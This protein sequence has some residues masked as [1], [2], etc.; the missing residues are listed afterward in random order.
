MAVLVLAAALIAAPAAQA[1]ITVGS[2]LSAPFDNSIGGNITAF[3]TAPASLVT[4][5]PVTGTVVGGNVKQGGSPVNAWGSASLR[6]VH[7]L[8]GGLY[9]VTASG[10]ANAIPAG[11]GIFPLSAHVAI[12][13]GDLVAIQGTGQ[14]DEA[15]SAGATYLF[16][17]TSTFPTG[18][19]PAMMSGGNTNTELLYNAQIDPTNT[20]TL[21]APTILKKGKAT[22]VVTVP[23]P[24]AIGGGS[25]ND[26]GLA[27]TAKKKKKKAK[28]LLAQVSATAAD[29]GPVTL[30]FSTSKAGKK[31]LREKGKLKT[32]AKIVY[33]P[34]GG[35][36][37]T[38]TIQLKLKP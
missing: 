19:P 15:I 12:A 34:T 29:A 26:T 25:S 10:P 33:T 8:P 18:G 7:T 21:G 28:P 3:P 32:S 14:V 37:S 4:A 30:T 27:A 24:G 36:A 22:V 16:R 38:Q 5:S 9:Q 20:F 35:S 17:I 2:T 1:A 31:L 23:N 6:V 13:K 11:S